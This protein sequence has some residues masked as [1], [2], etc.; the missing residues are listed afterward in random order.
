M[1][2]PRSLLPGSPLL[3]QTFF[4]F[5]FIFWNQMQSKLAWF[6]RDWSVTFRTPRVPTITRKKK[7]KWPTFVVPP[8][9]KKL[10]IRF[11]IRTTRVVGCYSK[12]IKFT[13]KVSL[14]VLIGLRRW[15]VTETG[16]QE[17]WTPIKQYNK[18][19]GKKQD[20]IYNQRIWRVLRCLKAPKFL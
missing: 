16:K 13:R 17:D 11:N 6:Q 3:A 7:K 2:S 14:S 19:P 12:L 8:I 4:P 5:S 10:L 20:L 15:Y 18:I 9:T 1:V